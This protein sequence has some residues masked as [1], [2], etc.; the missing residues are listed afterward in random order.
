MKGFK[1]NRTSRSKSDKAARKRFVAEL[2]STVGDARKEFADD[3]AGAR[4][5]WATLSPAGRRAKVEAEKRAAEQ[6][7]AQHR[8]RAEAELRA[9]EEAER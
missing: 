5:A 2:K 9:K 1:L 8:A 3:L 6:E 4:Q 7:A